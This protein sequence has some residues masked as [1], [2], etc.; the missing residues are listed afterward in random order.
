ME[1]YLR[2]FYSGLVILGIIYIY[3]LLQKS[4]DVRTDDFSVLEG[5]V[6]L[7]L[8]IFGLAI[9]HGVYWLIPEFNIHLPEYAY[10]ISI[11]MMFLAILILLRTFKDL[12]K[13]YSPTLQIFEYHG[14]ITSGIYKYV[15]HP[16]YLTALL[17]LLSQSLSLTNQ[18]GLVSNTIAFG[19]LL[20]LRIPA[21]EKM[22]IKEFS[23][24]YKK[25]MEKTDRL[26]PFIY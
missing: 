5:F 19:L 25:Y 3:F 6:L 10:Q 9:P 16:M 8:V 17:L 24:E 22:L 26:I 20:F 15:R 21:E 1:I 23:M 18:I 2:Y 11:I 7:G 14:L 13:Q 12:G 4:K